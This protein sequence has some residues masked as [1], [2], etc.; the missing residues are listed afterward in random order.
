MGLPDS[1]SGPLPGY[2]FPFTWAAFAAALTG[3][4]GSST[5]LSTRAAPN[6]P[7]KPSGCFAC[8]FPTGVRLHPSR[9]TG[10]FRIPIEAESGLLALRLACLPM[11]MLRQM[12]CSIPRLLGYMS[13]QAIYMMNSFQFTRSARLSWHTDR[14]GAE[15]ARA[16]RRCQMASTSRSSGGRMRGQRSAAPP[17]GAARFEE[18]RSLSRRVVLARS[19][20]TIFLVLSFRYVLPFLKLIL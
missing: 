19:A 10:H 1:R 8:C 13:E 2:V 20:R 7:G 18:T 16:S 14:E 6:H 4:P 15:S 17:F 9:R 3:L 5:D 11:P 12:G